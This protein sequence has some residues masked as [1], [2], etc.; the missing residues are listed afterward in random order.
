MNCQSCN[1]TIDY[2]FLANCSHCETQQPAPLDPM[3]DCIQL[4]KHPTWTKRVINFVYLLAS[5]LAGM[6]SGAMV[7]YFGTA[8]VCISFLHSTGN[9]SN[10]CARGNAIGALSIFT[11][12]FL[13][14]IG[15]SVFA[16]KKPLCKN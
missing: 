2:R 7:I 10:D 6:I 12:A 9:P 16:V 13:G 8:I 3:P 1:T 11:G 4:E 15:G 5:S 14:T